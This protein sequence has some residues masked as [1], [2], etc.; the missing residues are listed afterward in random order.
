MDKPAQHGDP[1][2]QKRWFDEP[3]TTREQVLAG[4]LRGAIAGGLA[5]VL[6]G[7][8]LD[9]GALRH[10]LLLGAGLGAVIGI[11]FGLLSR[12]GRYSI[13]VGLALWVPVATVFCAALFGMKQV[14]GWAFGQVVNQWV[15]GLGAGLAGALLG[16][17]FG[18]LFAFFYQ[19]F[20]AKDGGR[21]TAN[22]TDSM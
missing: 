22:F 6:G 7:G 11:V 19:R 21:R 2:P 15:Q 3:L 13:L 17:A 10:Q 4:A 5:G 16:F 12:G 9:M 8:I 14:I 18:G 1:P 20:R